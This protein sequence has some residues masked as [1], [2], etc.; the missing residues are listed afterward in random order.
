MASFLELLII[1]MMIKAFIILLTREKN[2]KRSEIV[3][4][5]VPEIVI[6]P[7]N[8]ELLILNDNYSFKNYNKIILKNISLSEDENEI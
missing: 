1:M 4:N 7:V 6:H 5:R 8:N 3:I 2:I